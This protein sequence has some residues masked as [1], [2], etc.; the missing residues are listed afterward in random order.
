MEVKKGAG[1]LWAKQT[2]TLSR[3][4]VRALGTH[5]SAVSPCVQGPVLQAATARW[6]HLHLYAPPPM[7][8]PTVCTSGYMTLLL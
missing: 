6:E 7:C 1:G 8:V 5:A 3:G 2:V 4:D